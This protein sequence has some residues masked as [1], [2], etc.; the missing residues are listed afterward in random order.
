MASTKRRQLVALAGA[1]PLAAV[2][3]AGAQPTQRAWRVGLVHVGD[4]HMPPSYEPMREGMRALGYQDGVH[5]RYDFRNVPD[6][7]AAL[8][9]A[10][11]LVQE[12]VDVIVA[13]DQEACNAA[14]IVTSTIPIVMINAGNPV[15]AGFVKTLARPGGNMTGF[16]GRPELPAKE[17]Q[18][19]KEM[20]P[21]IAKVLLLFDSHDSASVG[22]RNEVRSAARSL[23]VTLVERDVIKPADLKVIFSKLK[24]K[25]AEVVLFA[26]ATIRH[27][28]QKIVLDLA[29]A[30]GLAMVGS[31]KDTVQQGALFGYTNDFAKIGRAAAGRYLERVLKGVKP[32]ELAVEEVM[33]YEL[34]INRTVAKR[35]G[36]AIP[37]T[38][39]LRAVQI[40]D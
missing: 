19:L 6:E 37:P 22:W 14:H 26:S 15:A 32:G 30:R 8:A 7:K 24:P 10:R 13:F 27:R 36:W 18:I 20:V 4:D 9:A 40:F 28:Y 3:P 16:A 2:L 33:D 29:E 21:K 38:V 35:H 25:E 12:P 31:R 1:I 17:L 5:V 39:L 34:F 11:A 23:G